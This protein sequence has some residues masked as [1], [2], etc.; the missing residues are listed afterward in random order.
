[1]STPL[2][3]HDAG[4]HLVARPDGGVPIRAW[5]K[6]VPPVE[7][8]AQQQVANLASMPFIYRHVALLPDVH[9]GKGA[10]VGSVIATKGAIIPAACG[11]DIGCG[12]AAVK[13]SLRAEDLPDSL[14]ALRL[15]IEKRVPHGFQT[16]AGYSVKG[17][18]VAPTNEGFDRWHRLHWGYDAIVEKHPT[19][20][21]DSAIRQI[22]TLGGG[23]HFI[24]L[25]L[26]L[27]NNVWIMLHSGSRG[28]GNRIGSYFIDKAKEE[29]ARWFVDLPDQDLAYLPEGSPLFDDYCEAV[30]WA[31][32]YARENRKA[33]LIAV[34]A[35][36]R[37]I[38]PVRFALTDKAV[39]CHHNY[40]SREHH[41]GSN[42]FV[43]RKGAVRAREGDMGIIPG[44]MGARS[45]IVRGLGNAD[46]FCSCSHGAGRVMSRTA[47]KKAV[48]LEQHAAAVKGVECRVDADTIDE[49]P[50]AYKPIDLVMKSQEDLVEILYELRQVL[51]VKG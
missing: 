48:S 44:S 22:G 34:L 49:T 1:M 23:N 46:S 51:C 8:A 37:E 28:V 38:I 3:F 27:D 41:F 42:V 5:I 9:L 20:K 32:D 19:I 35:A 29:M 47:A 16:V 15:E 4:T 10:T 2:N 11:V 45:F 13:T 25:C 39:N 33:M 30:E 43:T 14:L 7:L 21:G 6:H 36:M 18:H 31:Q 40:I 12:M 26:D 50:A 17:C 24:E